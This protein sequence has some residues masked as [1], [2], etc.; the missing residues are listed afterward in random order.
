M[1]IKGEAIQRFL[2]MTKVLSELAVLLTEHVFIENKVIRL[3]Q[4]NEQST[5]FSSSPS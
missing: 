2:L 1:K 4:A 3:F 5:P